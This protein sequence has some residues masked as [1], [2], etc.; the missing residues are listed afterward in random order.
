ML[1]F[2]VDAY[3]LPLP[4]LASAP[5]PFP[6]LHLRCDGTLHILRATLHILR[7]TLQFLR[8]TLHILRA[9]LRI[10]RATLHIF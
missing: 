2:V 8:A 1:P 9:T 5:C 6:C 4:L 3:A 7:A 10:L